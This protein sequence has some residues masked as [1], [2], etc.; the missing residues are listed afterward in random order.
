[1]SY[2]FYGVDIMSVKMFLRM[3]RKMNFERGVMVNFRVFKWL[4]GFVG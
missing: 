3:E 4:I 2:G 1:M